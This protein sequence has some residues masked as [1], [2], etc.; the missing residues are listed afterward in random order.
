MMSLYSKPVSVVR[1][2][3]ITEPREIVNAYV[4]VIFP[5]EIE[6]F[7]GLAGT[8]VYETRLKMAKELIS[9]S[10][11][12]LTQTKDFNEVNQQIADAHA[13]SW[14]LLLFLYQD[15]TDQSYRND[16][17][18]EWDKSLNSNGISFLQVKGLSFVLDRSF[19]T[20]RFNDIFKSTEDNRTIASMC[21]VYAKIG[22]KDEIK[23]IRTRY[24]NEK[25]EAVRD[26]L[27][28][29]VFWW[30]AWHSGRQNIVTNIRPLEP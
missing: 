4:K 13:A 23:M 1:A 7:G 3:V 9:R 15:A 28:R 6:V 21:Y 2:T 17:L 25:R 19:M 16:I 30:E 8:N 12:M 5:N 20:E 24:D 14:A 29:T 18:Y 27:M 26:L 11:A 22:R 10:R